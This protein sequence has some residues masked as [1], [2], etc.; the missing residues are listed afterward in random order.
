MSRIIKSQQFVEAHPCRLEPV[1][2]DAF[3][4]NNPNQAEPDATSET[5][6]E[7]VATQDAG[8]DPAGAGIL[9]TWSPEIFEPD[10]KPD[11]PSSTPIA[12]EE[13]APDTG[14]KPSADAGTQRAAAE[15]AAAKT[16]EPPGLDL[17]H[18]ASVA[19]QIS[20][21]IQK[22]QSQSGAAREPALPI[23]R[24]G[25]KP[26]AA[27]DD[28]LSKEEPAET[29]GSPVKPFPKAGVHEEQLI[30]EAKKQAESIFGSAK[31]Q[32]GVLK[33][34]AKKEAESIFG[35]ARLEANELKEKAR[36]EAESF[37][38]GSRRQL[39]ELTA[40]A[41]KKAGTIL[42]G[43]QKEADNITLNANRRAESIVN[44]SKKQADLLM[45]AT[46]EKAAKLMEKVK[47]QADTVLAQAKEEAE[48][49]V[50]QAKEEAEQLHESSRAQAATVMETAK[51]EA[52]ALRE[53]ARK[54]GFETGRQ[55]AVNQV[56]Q[57]LNQNLTTALSLVAGAEAERI[58]RINS[59]E[60]EIL[61]LAVQIAEKIIGA[62]LKLDPARQMEIVRAALLKA[63]NAES[64]EVRIH[65]DDLAICEQNIR[66]LQEVFPD[67]KPI[68]FT[69]DPG[70]TPGSCFIETNLGNVDARL[71]SELDMIL[72]ELLKAR[73]IG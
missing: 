43:A 60:T 26:K 8:T 58:E 73:Q 54:E 35:K 38:E 53:E 59:S 48:R 30:A 52:A 45:E 51:Q 18:L 20:S 12:G 64:V 9:G 32:A 41:Q 33:E 19:E 72:A 34:T 39:S 67:P 65:P 29:S 57:E 14:E 44:D 10:L 69:G 23:M 37:L 56:K 66:Q 61:K 17:E 31:H 68:R 15:T 55:D 1:D 2:V 4:I 28:A 50:A 49:I 13:E 42:T 27:G 16:V 11:P 47:Q 62:E 46:R 25:A 7:N 21:L 24:D 63:T 71:K 5:D 70:L 40:D 22:A 3:F 36:K 6:S